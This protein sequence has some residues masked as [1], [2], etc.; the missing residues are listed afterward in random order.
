MELHILEAL[1]LA[2]DRDAALAE[3]VPCTEDHDYWR[4]IRLQ[5]LG[6][7]DAVDPILD[8]WRLL[9]TTDIYRAANPLLDDTD[10]DGLYFE[11]DVETNYSE[12]FKGPLNVR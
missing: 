9:D 8:G 6:N 1:A 4:A 3:L 5:N 2:D 12:H 11:R 10:G 7:L